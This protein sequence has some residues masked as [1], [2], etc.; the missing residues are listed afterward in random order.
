MTALALKFRDF[1]S[2]LMLDLELKFSKSKKAPALDSGIGKLDKK[3]ETSSSYVMPFEIRMLRISMRQR[4]RFYDSLSTLVG[5]GVTLLDSLAL[6]RAQSPQKGLK[7]LYGE[8]MHHINTGLSL[9]QSL[10]L[11]PHLFPS[12]QCALIEA[13]EKSGNLKMVLAELTEEIEASH[14][15]HRKVT[16]AM[17]Y[18]IILVCMSV[19]LVTGMMLFVI[20]KISQMYAQAR[21]ALPWLT[22]MVIDISKFI[23]THAFE[24]FGGLIGITALMVFFFTRV[25]AGRLFLENMI[26]ITPILGRL[27]R[28]RNLMSITSN[29]AML[30]NSGV[31]IVEAFQITEKTLDHLHYKRQIASVRQGIMLGREISQM[32]GLEDLRASKFSH[33]RWFPLDIVQMIHIGETTGTL[34]EMFLKIKKNM[35]KSIDYTLRNISTLIEPVMIFFI[36]A[37]VGSILLA[38]MLP[39]FYIGNTVS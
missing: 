22:Q 38:V 5:S 35:R 16:G 37:L 4:L 18:P 8:I 15:F 7:K 21:V 26:Y 31:Q 28:E 19:L 9:A 23:S 39:F 20:P 2:D 33:N 10:A 17:V 3:D 6:V 34:S 1:F 32:M 14:D 11:Y 24:L 36:A 29:M 25:T 12:M 30:L 13:A 27:S